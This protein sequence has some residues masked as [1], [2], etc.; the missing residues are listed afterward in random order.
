MHKE[1]EE[2]DL[3]FDLMNVKV[4]KQPLTTHE[5]MDKYG[6]DMKNLRDTEEWMCDFCIRLSS[7]LL[8]LPIGLCVLSARGAVSYLT[9]QVEGLSNV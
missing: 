1:E 2:M 3:D 9:F 8:M 5:A 4:G 6:N 7:P